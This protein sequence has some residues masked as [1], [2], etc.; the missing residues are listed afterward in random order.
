MWNS[1]FFF[2]KQDFFVCLFVFGFCFFLELRTEPRALCLL[3][4]CSTTELN[5]QPLMWRFLWNKVILVVVL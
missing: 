1:F 3:G 5:P 4:K 2:F